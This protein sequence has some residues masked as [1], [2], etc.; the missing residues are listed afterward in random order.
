M[1]V[2]EPPVPGEGDPEREG[3]KG[4][5]GP[6]GGPPARSPKA[7]RSGG[8]SLGGISRGAAPQLPGRG[9]S[10]PARGPTARAGQVEQGLQTPGCPG[11]LGGPSSLVP[12][13]VTTSRH[14]L[15][16][17][18]GPWPAGP[19]ARP[20]HLRLQPCGLHSGPQV[21]PPS[22]VLDSVVIRSRSVQKWPGP[23][24]TESADKGHG[25]PCSS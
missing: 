8:L 12:Q 4:A 13:P 14:S 9:R 16:A 11:P 21:S 15:E 19:Q 24:C 5:G 1:R 22:G 3:A 23:D 7:S 6:E 20:P 25:C 18:P 10:L 2:S 17:G